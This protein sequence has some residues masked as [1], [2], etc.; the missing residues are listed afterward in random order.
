MPTGEARVSLQTPGPHR[1]EPMEVG[2]RNHRLQKRPEQ[3]LL[4]LPMPRLAQA[5]CDGPGLP[6]GSELGGQ[7]SWL[8]KAHGPPASLSITAPSTTHV[9]RPLNPAQSLMSAFNC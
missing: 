5:R 4:G 2:S 3:Q 7:E 8:G 9:S 6:T 1:A